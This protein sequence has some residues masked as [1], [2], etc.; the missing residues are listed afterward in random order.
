MKKLIVII[1]LFVGLLIFS[2]P[3]HI[4]NIDFSNK[5]F[6]IPN[7]LFGI[8][9]EDINH[10]IDGGLYAELV[11]NGSFEQEMRKYEGWLIKTE[12][13]CEITIDNKT[14]LNKNNSHYLYLYFPSTSSATIS[15]LG[16]GGIPVFLNQEYKFSVFVKGNFI[17]SIEV[18]LEKNN[19]IFSKTY[20]TLNKE[21]ENWTKITNTLIPTKTS[22]NAQLTLKFTGK[23]TLNI[24][25]ISL[26]NS[27]T[28]YNMRNDLLKSLENLRPG[29]VRFPGGCLVEGNNLKNAYNWKESIGPIE[30]RNAKW[31]LWGYYQ[32]LGIGFFEY[33]LLSEKLKAEP[34]PVFNAG[35]SCQVR[36][37]E[38][39]SS[40]ELDI[41]IQD[42]L[43]FIE[44]ANGSTQTT[45]GKVRASLGHPEPFN[46][47]YIGVGNENWGL[48][49]QTNFKK[50]YEEIKSKYPNIKIIFSG[51]PSY[52][53]NDF[54]QSWKWAKD[55]NVEIFDEHIYA[56]PEWLLANADRYKKYDRNGPKVMLG[57]YAA[58]TPDRK[59]NFQA[60][61]AE[62]AFMTGLEKNSDVV[63]M[64]S[65]APLFNK[66]GWSQWTPDLIWFDN[67][68][69]FGTPSYYVQKLF[70]TNKGDFLIN[71]TL[72]NE[73][74]L[75]M[76]Y[77]YKSLYHSVTYD[78]Q[79]K[80]LIIKVVNPWADTKTVE[81]N[82]NGISVEGIGKEIKLKGNLKSE[83][84]FENLEIAPIEKTI[85][86]IENSFNYR[87]DEFS[88]TILKLKIK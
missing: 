17:G 54:R 45:W 30:E 78:S 26:I 61:L 81:I 21:L 27:D 63:I 19:E 33:L 60:A 74:Y 14:P 9:F 79:A 44:F 84:N 35:M 11:R 71:S 5:E 52:E 59:N 15:N 46:V 53:G 34:I 73:K 57:E 77:K 76:G 29:F 28:F 51:P 36:G 47:K 8:F 13:S 24:D 64:A 3:D 41:F 16:Y 86:G 49:Y 70:S 56:A 83:N 72:S 87:F 37:A 80:E 38:Y 66:V 68:R 7:T 12:N 62:A 65:Y 42:V 1:S 82:I 32:S 67:Y 40:D 55:N 48:K 25:M 10:A 75:I 43:D 4:L 58:H 39:C 6:E 69:Y 85:V 18:I 88:I 22:T 2:S 20:I 31:N 23:G 50:F